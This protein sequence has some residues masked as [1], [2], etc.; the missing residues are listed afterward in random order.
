[1]EHLLQYYGQSSFAIG[2]RT[3]VTDSLLHV[4]VHVHVHGGLAVMLS[5]L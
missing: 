5:G 3:G 2:D 1:M 4:H